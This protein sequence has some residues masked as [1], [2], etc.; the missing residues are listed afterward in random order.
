MIETDKIVIVEGKYD[1]IKLSSVI[2]ANII[3]TGGFE[4]FKNKEKQELIRKLGEKN[5]VIILTDSDAAGFKIRGFL[6]GILPDDRITNL[7]IPDIFGKERRKTAPGKEGKLGV[8]GME[9]ELLIKLFENIEKGKKKTSVTSND[10]YS[11]GLSGGDKSAE[12]RRLV[13]KELGLPERLSSKR[14]CE[15]IGALY[16]K[17]E[18]IVLA[19]R[20]LNLDKKE[21]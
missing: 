17:E 21:N 1:K 20:I 4:L 7:Y 16:E 12:K 8:E 18:F 19:E 2:K 3:E 6:N 11:L 9:K 10:L 13:L 5:G 15:I 14:M